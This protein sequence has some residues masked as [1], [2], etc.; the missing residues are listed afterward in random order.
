M[1]ILKK[2]DI[3]QHIN[4]NKDLIPIIEEAFKSLSNGKTVMP[5]IMRIDIEKYHGESDVKDAYVDGFDSF[6]RKI[7][8]DFFD[9]PKFILKG[10]ERKDLLELLN[11]NLKASIILQKIRKLQEKKIGIKNDRNQ[12]LKDLENEK[13]IFI[14][15]YNHT[16]RLIKEN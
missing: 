9:N 7:A 6:A 2:K 15:F 5:P 8:S 10:K 4:L 13:K 11:C 16:Y 12:R 14:D 1:L 3:I